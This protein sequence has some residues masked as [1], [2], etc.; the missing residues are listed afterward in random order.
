MSSPRAEPR[1]SS[2]RNFG[3][4]RLPYAILLALALVVLVLRLELVSLAS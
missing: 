1:T 4:L 2:G 3:E